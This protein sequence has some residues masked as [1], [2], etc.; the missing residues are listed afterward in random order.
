MRKCT[1]T[2]IGAYLKLVAAFI[3]HI[4]YHPI[5]QE[6]SLG[7]VATWF[8]VNRFYKTKDA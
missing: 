8:V 4:L 6:T 2:A 7:F 3:F 1:V 5:T